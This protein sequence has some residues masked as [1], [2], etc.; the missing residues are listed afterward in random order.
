MFVAALL[1]AG[2]PRKALD[3]Q[4]EALPLEF[5][6]KVS[7]VER[8][9]F[10]AR[11][12][13]V[14]IPGQKRRRA[15]KKGASKEPGHAHAHDHAPG[16]DH[17]PAHAHAQDEH[18]LS[19]HAHGRRWREIERLLGRAKLAPTV[20]DRALGIFE[21]L[22]R[23]EADV[24]G[25]SLD[26]VHFHEVGMVDAI[27]DVTAAAAGLELLGVGR[28][29]C[30][31]VGIGHGFVDT[32]HGRL[33]VPTPATLALL[34]GVPTAP[35]D[36]AW[37]TITPTGA[38]ILREV[39]D[40]FVSWPGIVVERVGVGA[41]RERPG[42]MPNVVRAMLGAPSPGVSTDRIVVIETNVDDLVPEHFDY[43]LERLMEAGAVDVS[44]QHVQMKKNRPGFLLR[45][46]C[47]PAARDTVAR[48]L[49]AETS[50]IGLRHQEWDRIVL[51]RRARRVDTPWGRLR[52]KEV[53]A[54]DGAPSFSAEYDDCR[55]AAKRSGIALRE[56]VRETEA[57]ARA[58]F[59]GGER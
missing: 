26:D 3:A 1:D 37:E 46:L 45:V 17:A 12:V 14:V 28:V 23:A 32:A 42:P 59:G 19:H 4:L 30:S 49:F 38:A 35:V 39:V 41:G 48:T 20:R 58:A 24:H 57:L 13:D 16:H 50:A 56:I 43:A 40:E 22:A 21:G 8:G 47:P 5:K 15:K 55:K 9:G 34:Q 18:H 36:V 44:I 27:V 54:P 2:L 11:Y 52:V 6:L 33:P 51:E 53:R 7:R 29:T 10:A 31:P 25:R